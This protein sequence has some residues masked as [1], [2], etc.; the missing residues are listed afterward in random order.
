MPAVKFLAEPV[1]QGFA[2]AIRR[3]AQT[4]AL[5]EFQHAAAILAADDTH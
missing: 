5:G 2:D 1:E 3:W 4:F